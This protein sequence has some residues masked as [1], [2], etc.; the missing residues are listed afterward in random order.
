MRSGRPSSGRRGPRSPPCCRIRFAWGQHGSPGT[1]G[2]T[3]GGVTPGATGPPRGPGGRR[4]RRPARGP[5]PAPGTSKMAAS[6]LQGGVAEQR[7]EGLGADRPL[8]HVLV[9]V[10]VGP[11]GDLGVVQVQATAAAPGRSRGRSRPAPASASSTVANDTPEAHRCWVSRQTP[12]SGPEP[13]RTRASSA[14]LRP[15]VPPAPAAFSSRIGQSP[16]TSSRASE[17]GRRPPGARTFEPQP[18]VAADV[19]H[20]ARGTHPRGRGQVG[21]QAGPGPGEQLGVG[22]GQVDEVAGVAE[23]GRDQR[24]GGLGGAVAVEDLGG[25][26]GGLPGTRALGEDLD[27]SAPISSAR[28]SAGTSFPPARTW[29]PISMWRP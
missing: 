21:H 26:L 1:A 13:S 4:P 3:S 10:A 18:L 9:T 22:R 12:S 16:P 24:V 29:A 17:Q 23:R 11:E 20:Q 28:S 6:A 25:V 14:K 8:A 2:A 5:S 15:I 7:A 27:A 19:Q